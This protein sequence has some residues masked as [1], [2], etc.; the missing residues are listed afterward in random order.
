M[1]WSTY[2][3]PQ[4]R[5]KRWLTFIYNAFVCAEGIYFS[6]SWLR[7]KISTQLCIWYGFMR[8]YVLK[9]I[10]HNADVF[11]RK[12]VA[13]FDWKCILTKQYSLAS[14]LKCIRLLLLFVRFIN[15]SPEII[16]KKK[17]NKRKEN[18]FIFVWASGNAELLSN[19]T[20]TIEY[21]LNF[22]IT[23]QM[24]VAPLEGCK[25]YNCSLS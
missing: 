5:V 7:L 16:K 8:F 10:H 13:F 1:A 19:K 4:N 15:M 24:F 20:V 23:T 12:Q 17:N 22:I 2:N 14:I 3:L 9:I 18:V 21:Y 11:V 6:L 25:S